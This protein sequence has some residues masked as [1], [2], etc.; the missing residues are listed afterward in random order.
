MNQQEQQPVNQKVQEEDKPE[1]QIEDLSVEGAPDDR[2]VRIKGGV[3]VLKRSLYI[4]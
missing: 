3:D 4:R 2:D 1:A